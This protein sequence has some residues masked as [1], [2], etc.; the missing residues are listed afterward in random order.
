MLAILFFFFRNKDII[1]SK[2]GCIV[3]KNVSTCC[4]KKLYISEIAHTSLNPSFSVAVTTTIIFDLQLWRNY[5]NL[6]SFVYNLILHRSY[7][8]FNRQQQ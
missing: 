4:I 3:S 7:F 6:V 5:C 1:Q 8:I 2:C